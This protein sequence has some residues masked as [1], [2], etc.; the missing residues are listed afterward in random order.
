M[1]TYNPESYSYITVVEIPKSEILKFDMA[2]CAEPRQTLKNFY[3]SCSVKPTIVCNGGFFNM[4]DGSTCFNYTDEGKIINSNSSFKEGF[5]TVNGDLQYGIIGE[6][7][8]EDFISAYPVLI[9]Q[10]KKI[11]I[12]IATE[13]DYKARR[14][15]L[16]YDNFN[17]YIIAIESP[18]MDFAQMQNFLLSMKIEYA[19]NLDGGGSTKIL[20]DGKSLTSCL[21]NRAVDNVIAVYLKPQTIYRVQVG[22][23]ASKSNA[24]EFLMTVQSLGGVCADAYVRKVNNYYKI[25]VGAFSVRANA[26]KVVDFLKEKGFTAFI[27]S[28]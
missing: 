25:Q 22:S 21:Y 3:D 5:G 13:L 18:G 1:R 14:T 7:S 9:K 27:S 8:F 16:A 20:K 24:T 17:V 15:I 6:K 26:Q 12:S 11:N 2:L 23:F 28:S 10:G 4:T 19:I